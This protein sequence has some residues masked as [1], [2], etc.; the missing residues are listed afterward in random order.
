M[1]LGLIGIAVFD[2]P[3]VFV[4]FAVLGRRRRIDP[5]RHVRRRSGRRTR[6]TAAG[7]HRQH[8]TRISLGLQPIGLLIGGVLIDTIGGTRTWPSGRGSCVVAPIFVPVKALRT[9]SLGP[10]APTPAA[11]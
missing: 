11:G 9:A 5:G 3:P 6:R 2:Q 10:K 1:G 8:R 4:G 7:P